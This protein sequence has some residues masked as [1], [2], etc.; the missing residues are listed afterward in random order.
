MWCV[1]CESSPASHAACKRCDDLPQNIQC[2][3][4]SVSN[5]IVLLLIACEPFMGGVRCVTITKGVA[6]GLVQ[7]LETPLSRAVHNGHL[8]TARHLLDKGADVNCLD[9]V[10]S[11]M[12]AQTVRYDENEQALRC[13]RRHDGHCHG[14]VVWRLSTPLH[15][16]VCVRYP[17]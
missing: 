16:G 17:T 4:Q 8:Q 6:Y 9:I 7:M 5:P 1:A 12:L 10:R 13:C 3:C 11:C 2:S 15:Q 14:A